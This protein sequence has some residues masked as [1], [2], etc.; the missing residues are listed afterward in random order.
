MLIASVVALLA[1]QET[2]I[3]ART[4]REVY[5]TALSEYE[6]AIAMT[7]S[8]PGQALQLIDRVFETKRILTKDRR[9]IIERPIAGNKT[10]DFFPNQARGRIRLVLAKSDPDNAATLIAGAVA[11]LKASVDAGVRSSEDL[12][13]S[14]RLAQERLKTVK[15]PEPAKDNSAE[16]SLRESWQKLIDDRKWKSA[17]ELLEAKGG[18]LP[19]DSMK[20]LL[21]ETEDRCRKSVA[22]ALDEFLKSLQFNPRPPLLRQQK[23]A[24]FAKSFALPPDAELVVRV[25]EL[26]WARKERPLLERIRDSEF[27]PK[28]EIGMPLLEDLIQGMLET[29]P[30]EKSGEDWWFKASGQVAYHFLE[31]VVHGLAL[32]SQSAAPADGRKLR[33]AA[34][35]ATA[36]WS[37]GLAKLPKDFLARNPIHESPRRL[38]AL[39]DEFPIDSVEV[40]QIDLNAC[41]LGTS[42]DLA[43]EQLISDL[44]KIRDQKESRLSKDSS[45]KLLSLLVAA[46][47]AHELLAG[48]TVEEVTKELQ[49]VG[50][51]L[52]KAG[53]PVDPALWGPRIEKIFAGLK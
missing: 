19:A 4:H 28:A 47:S 44:S 26:D 42:P 39:L 7:E 25:P 5:Q 34:E 41:F 49:E 13:R 18:A 36:K 46:S 37:E 8:N 40:D 2:D 53:G 14:A 21:R 50:R 1:L 20:A 11:D 29:E 10:F 9:L 32:R 51:S 22:Q 31:E 17:K 35:Q 30:F 38:A 15:P 48:K 23:P 24:D 16:K 45:R 27:Q 43:L 12:L 6:R 33:E 52:A 3:I